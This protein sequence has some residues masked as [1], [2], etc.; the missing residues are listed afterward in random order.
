MEKTAKNFMSLIFE[1]KRIKVKCMQCEQNNFAIEWEI[2]EGKEWGLSENVEDVAIYLKCLQC[3][4]M[5]R[6]A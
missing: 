3:G 5:E 6:V 2:H 4:N 1:P